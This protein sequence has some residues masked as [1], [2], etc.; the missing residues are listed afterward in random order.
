MGLVRKQGG[1]K[2]DFYKLMVM[3]MLL[4]SYFVEHFC[5]CKASQ[6]MEYSEVTEDL[7]AVKPPSW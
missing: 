4:A 5:E 1:W 3:H 2:T 6:S 7:G